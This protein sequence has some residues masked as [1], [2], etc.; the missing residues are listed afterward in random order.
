MATSVTFSAAGDAASVALTPLAD[1]QDPRMAC[2]LSVLQSAFR[3][4][5]AR[6]SLAMM[7]RV[8]LDSR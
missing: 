2:I 6:G 1:S 7:F 4:V 3:I 8:D 5:P